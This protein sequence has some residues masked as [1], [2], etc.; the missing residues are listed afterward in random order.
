VAIQNNWT[1]NE[2]AA[3]LLSVLQDHAA[4]ILHIVQ[5]QMTYEDIVGA[6]PDRFG[7]HQL[8]APY[9]SQLMARVQMSGEILQEFAAAV[10]HQAHRVLVGLPVALIQTAASHAFNGVRNQEVKQNILMG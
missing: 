10:K 8:A 3:H 2:K 1:P 9:W 7:D 5:A 6:H 4:D